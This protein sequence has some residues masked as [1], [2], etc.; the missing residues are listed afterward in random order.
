VITWDEPKRQINLRRHKID[1][2]EVE[3]VFDGPVITD[4]DERD[5]YGELR[6]QTFGLWRGRVVLL[7]W[8]PR[9]EDVAHL[10]S[11]RYANRQETDRYFEAL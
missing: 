11:C 3:S 4:E 8:T 9:A 1:L 7:V 2:A 5:D 10:I 6:L